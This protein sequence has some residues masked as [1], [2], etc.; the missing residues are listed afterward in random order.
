[1]RKLALLL[2]TTLLALALCWLNDSSFFSMKDEKRWFTALAAPTPAG[3]RQLQLVSE[4]A[5]RFRAGEQEQNSEYQKALKTFE[6]R[7]QQYVEEVAAYQKQRALL[8][9]KQA[10]DL[11]NKQRARLV[12]NILRIKS[13]TRRT[14]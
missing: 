9:K 11:E 4:Y 13:S 7:N 6:D 12:R 5:G 2:S 3:K 1:M 14:G 10:I 8:L